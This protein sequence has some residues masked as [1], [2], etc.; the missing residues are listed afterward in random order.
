[1]MKI[2]IAVTVMMNVTAIAI[3]MMSAMRLNAPAVT[4]SFTS[5][6]K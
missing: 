5:M 2:A 6:M 1:M 3:V 4:T